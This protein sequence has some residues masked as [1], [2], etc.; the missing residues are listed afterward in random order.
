[1]KQHLE[2]SAIAERLRSLMG[3][4]TEIGFARKLGIC[5]DSIVR[6]LRGQV[7]DP[8]SLVR[9]VE[10]CDVS[11]DWLLRGATN[12]QTTP[13]RDADPD[14]SESVVP[15]PVNLVLNHPALADTRGLVSNSILVKIIRD[16]IHEWPKF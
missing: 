2:P 6:Y 12:D 16:V 11:S 5:Q 8:T 3:T 7:P 10:V 13:A 4:D 15:P 14:A 9:I 1:M